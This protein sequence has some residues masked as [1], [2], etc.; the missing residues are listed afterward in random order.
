MA[1]GSP[2]PHLFRHWA[3][4]APGLT[5]A[6]SGST[7]VPRRAG[8]ARGGRR[9]AVL[10]RRASVRCAAL[11]AA[12][13]VPL[14]SGC[15]R[16]SGMRCTTDVH[17]ACNIQQPTYTRHAMYNGV[18]CA[19]CPGAA[20]LGAA[21]LD[22]ARTCRL[23]T[24]RVPMRTFALQLLP[25]GLRVESLALFSQAI[26]LNRPLQSTASA[27]RPRSS[28][29]P[30]LAGWLGV[31]AGCS[32]LSCSPILALAAVSPTRPPATACAQGCGRSKSQPTRRAFWPRSET[33]VGGHGTGNLCSSSGSAAS[34]AQE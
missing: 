27:H 9:A 19:A 10:S 1:R 8:A 21:G 29:F 28:V 22:D 3:H 14:R 6:T 26:G 4:P 7:A 18:H 32:A 24:H 20:G 30:W 23:S 15:T 17:L 11:G 33:G 13:A 12:E 5:A 16:P 25:A 34:D 31:C 2:L